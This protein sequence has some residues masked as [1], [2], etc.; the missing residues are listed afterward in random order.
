MTKS[1]KCY[2][3]DH[4]FEDSYDE[5]SHLLNMHDTVCTGNHEGNCT[6]KCYEDV[7]VQ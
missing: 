2:F 3:C 5:I 4:V 7:R 1:N 6:R